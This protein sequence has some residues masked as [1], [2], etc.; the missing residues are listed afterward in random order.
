[1]KSKYLYHI[2]TKEHLPLI[3]QLGLIP[4]IGENSRIGG[5][6]EPAVYLC[7]RADLPFWKILLGCNQD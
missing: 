5:E 2:T 6:P 7:E 1:M 3:Q 4:M